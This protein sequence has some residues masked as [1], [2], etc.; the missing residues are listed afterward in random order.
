MDANCKLARNQDN[1]TGHACIHYKNDAG[2]ERL[3]ELMT[4]IDL[5][6]ASTRFSS[7]KTSPQG[8][9]T[10]I[11]DKAAQRASQLDYILVDNKHKSN[12]LSCRVRWDRSMDNQGNKQDHG[13]VCMRMRF[14]IRAHK[15][16][17]SHQ[18]D[19]DALQDDTIRL[20][21]LQVCEAV[22]GP[23]RSHDR[24][25]R[26]QT[27]LKA[28]AKVLPK[29]QPR[30]MIERGTSRE[31]QELVQQR[32]RKCQAL[33]A[34]D[35]AGLRAVKAVFHKLVA[36]SCRKDQRDH[37]GR[38]IALVV[39]ADE[40]GDSREWWKA[41][42]RISGKSRRS[43]NTMPEADSLEEVAEIFAEHAETLLAPSTREAARSR[44]PLPPASER[45][46]DIP[47]R[48]TVIKHLGALPNNKAAGPSG[49][50]KELYS[51]GGAIEADLV[52][53]VQDVFETEVVPYDMALA[54]SIWLDGKGR[55][56]RPTQTSVEA[57]HWRSSL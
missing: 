52:Q 21:F 20:K 8:Q 6:A 17:D 3:V 34:T 48:E 54:D 50:P 24:Y 41:V 28:A 37:I 38:L 19:R 7:P 1:L 53:V 30:P 4:N 14:R 11:V 9:G 31:T 39:E 40:S 51:V 15:K 12:M 13:M 10:Y 5:M 26:L 36:R 43:N 32:R 45:S 49:L 33:A 27:A 2:G 35:R 56:A 18:V 29:P 44:A 16:K 46:E 25:A 47:S 23:R 22:A 42:H 57:C 55:A